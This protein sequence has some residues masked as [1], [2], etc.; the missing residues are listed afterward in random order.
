M[1]E[2]LDDLVTQRITH[3]IKIANMSIGFNGNP[4]LSTTTRAKVNTAVN[5]GIVLC[6]SAGNDGPGTFRSE[7]S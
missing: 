2:A 6:I 3:N 1:N 4:G 7:C 5:N